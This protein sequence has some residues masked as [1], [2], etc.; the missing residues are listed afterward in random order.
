MTSESRFDASNHFTVPLLD[1]EK[2]TSAD[3]VGISIPGP[4]LGRTR[5]GVTDQFLTEADGY[6]ERYINLPHFRRLIEEALS[7]FGQLPTDPHILDMG[8]G[9]GN[10][11]LPCLDLLDQ[12]L[13][14]ATDIS[15]NLLEILRHS[16]DAEPRYKGRTALVC[17]DATQDYF[18][19]SSFDLVVGASILHHL[20][21][22]AAA[23]TAA[24]KALKP[25]GH[26]V[27]FEAF[28]SGHAIMRIA[29]T[30]ILS[31]VEHGRPINP[32]ALAVIQAMLRDYQARM[33]LTPDSPILEHLDDKWFFTRSFF[34]TQA[35]NAGFSGV[36]IYPLH[37]L[38][39]PFSGQLRVHLEL[40]D[41]LGPE[42]L[43]DWAWDVMR[44]FDNVI[45]DSLKPDLLLEGTVILSK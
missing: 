27:F 19:H 18:A 5:L 38:D 16:L 44:F 25:G 11:V 37:P 10:T 1:L 2:V 15:P 4:E 45:S 3:W 9:S 39:A 32:S 42:A 35:K 41:G 17:L 12:S 6:H 26:A 40:A 33:E 21:E 23:I 31:E 36:T 22:P 7:R 29:Y 43:D 24:A 20:I 13:I 14:V 28:E 8:S 34:E 30:Q